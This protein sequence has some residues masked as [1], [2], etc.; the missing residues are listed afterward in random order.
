VWLDDGSILVATHATRPLMR[1]PSAGGVLRLVTS[2]DSTRAER[3][4]RWPDVLPGGEW[5]IFTVGSEQSRNY[6]NASS[7]RLVANRRAPR[8]VGGR[9]DGAL[10]RPGYLL[11]SRQVHYWPCQWIPTTRKSPAAGSDSRPSRPRAEQRRRSLRGRAQR[12]AGLCTAG[13]GIRPAEMVWISFDGIT[14]VVPA[15]GRE[16]NA[17]RVS[18]DGNQILVTI[19]PSYGIGD[20]WRYDLTRDTLTRLT[21]NGR[22][23]VGHWTPISAA[24]FFRTR[25]RRSGY[26]D[27]CSTAT[28]R[29]RAVHR[30]QPVVTSYVTPDGRQVLFSQ[31]EARK[32]T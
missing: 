23:L 2:L 17:P 30:K 10:L 7:R 6:E 25:T 20:L 18:P 31:W 32:R 26:C 15:P 14:T 27:S 1:V 8:A 21:F 4:H 22:T 29:H 13:G 9:V 19:G 3:T 24:S 5:V 28:R 16:Y 11:F 12:H